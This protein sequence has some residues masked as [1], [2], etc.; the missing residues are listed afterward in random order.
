MGRVLAFERN[1]N[2][3]HDSEL[4]G[5]VLQGSGRNGL[6]SHLEV[7]RSHGRRDAPHHAAN[8]RD[9]QAPVY[10]RIKDGQVRSVGGEGG[11]GCSGET[12]T[13]EYSA[14]GEGVGRGREG[15]SG[16]AQV[17]FPPHSYSGCPI[18]N[19]IIPPLRLS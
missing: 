14:G 10:G 8:I 3:S 4:V 9:E 18:S 2:T 13:G 19:S 7:A 6:R 5:T 16:C 15:G 12:R 17:S 11:C 1:V